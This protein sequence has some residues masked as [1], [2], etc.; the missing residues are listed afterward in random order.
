MDDIRIGDRQDHLGLAGAKASVEHILQIDD[1]GLA[2]GEMLVLH[3]VIG[4]DAR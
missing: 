2:I 3:A 1:V 4:D